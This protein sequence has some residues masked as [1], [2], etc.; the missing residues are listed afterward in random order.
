LS[1]PVALT[2]ESWRQHQ[3]GKWTGGFRIPG[4]FLKRANE[5][6]RHKWRIQTASTT[7][8]A[9]DQIEPASDLAALLGN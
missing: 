4:F 3:V 9:I 1:L 6:A 8:A 2:T 5:A 7:A